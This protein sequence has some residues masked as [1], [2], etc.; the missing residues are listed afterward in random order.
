MSL[1]LAACAVPSDRMSGGD[2]ADLVEALD[3]LVAGEPQNCMTSGR[4]GGPDIIGGDAILYR[5]SAGRIWLAKTEGACPWLRP[6]TVLI[7]EVTGSQLCRNDRFQV[8]DRGGGIPS[9]YCRF[10]SFTPYRRE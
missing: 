4:I 2:R 3:G 10:G 9:G 7:V 8:V 1:G 5:E 6:D